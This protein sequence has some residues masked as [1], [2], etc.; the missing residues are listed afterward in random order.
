[1]R[2]LLTNDDGIQ[3]P[4]LAALIGV[5]A[6]MAEVLV[7]APES[8]RSAT[9]HAIKVHRPCRTMRVN[10]PVESVETHAMDANPAD[11][12]KYALSTL[13]AQTPPDLVISGINRGQNTGNNVIYSGTVAAAIEAAMYGVPAMAISLAARFGQTADFTVAADWARH[14]APQIVKQ[15]LP[16]GIVINVNVP[17]LPRDQIRGALWTRQGHARFTDQFE[18]RPDEG[19]QGESANGVHLVCNVGDAMTISGDADND[20]C[21]LAAGH[22]TVSPLTYDMTHPGLLAD[23]PAFDLSL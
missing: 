18:E 21:A 13:W 14:L 22:V 1:M 20:D 16:T 19:P 11:C 2:I 3:A 23:P 15:G 4:G 7:V 6:P 17:N 10:H 5:I 8:E 12:V 9:A